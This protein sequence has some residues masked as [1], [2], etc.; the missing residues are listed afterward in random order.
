MYNFLTKNGQILAFGVGVLITVLYYVIVSSG[1]EAFN[2]IPQPDQPKSAEGDIFY[3]GLYAT[4]LLLL[5]AA[6]LIL[7]FG[8]YQMVTHP[9]AAV[10]GIIGIGILAAIFLISYSLA[11]PAGTGSL[12]ATMEE[13]NITPGVSKYIS[14]ALTT[15]GILAVLAVLSFAISEIRNFFR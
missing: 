9:K 1:L 12:K 2:S 4:F 7:V 11:D 3:F 14:A 5:V 15:T 13:F 10:K 8:I 6:G